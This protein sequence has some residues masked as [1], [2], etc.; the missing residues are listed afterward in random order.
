MI[1]ITVNYKR[2]HSKAQGTNARKIISEVYAFFVLQCTVFG[3]K[4]KHKTD[5]K[6]WNPFSQKYS[7]NYSGNRKLLCEFSQLSKSNAFI[8]LGY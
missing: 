5:V 8:L 6:A 1:R 3:R 7:M 2:K 4:S